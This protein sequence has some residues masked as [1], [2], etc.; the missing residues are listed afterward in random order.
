MNEK[1]RKT[2]HGLLLRREAELLREVAETEADLALLDEDRESEDEERAQLDST[3][4]LLARLD[5]RATAEVAE[6][7]AALARLALGAYGKCEACGNRIPIR[8]LR[9]APTARFCVACARLREA[10]EPDELAAPGATHA[11]ARELHRDPRA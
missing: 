1:T 4:H 5:D 2:L 3:A 6:I 9:S 7:R 10:I 8:R 11:G